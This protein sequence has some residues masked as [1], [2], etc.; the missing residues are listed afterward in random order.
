[1]Y[2][3][4]KL[5]KGL[6]LQKKSK[7]QESVLKINIE[8]TNC[9]PSV[10]EKNFTDKKDGTT[11]KNGTESVLKINIEETN[12]QPSGNEKNFTDKKD[13]TTEKNGTEAISIVD[14]EI[15]KMIGTFKNT[16]ETTQMDPIGP[17]VEF[18]AKNNKESSEDINECFNEKSNE[19]F[20]EKSNECFNEKSNECFNEKSNE[21]FN[22]KSNECFNEESNECFNEE[23]GRDDQPPRRIRKRYLIADGHYTT[24]TEIEEFIASHKNFNV[25]NLVDTFENVNLEEYGVNPPSFNIDYIFPKYPKIDTYLNL[26]SIPKEECKLQATMSHR[27]MIPMD[28]ETLFNT[29]NSEVCQV[30]GKNPVSFRLKDRFLRIKKVNKIVY[31]F[32]KDFYISYDMKKLQKW[33]ICATDLT[34]NNLGELIILEKGKTIN[35]YKD[36][37]LVQRV[38]LNILADG[39]VS[40]KD[41]TVVLSTYNKILFLLN[42]DSLDIEIICGPPNEKLVSLEIVDDIIVHRTNL[43]LYFID[44]GRR[45]RYLARFKTW[46]F[47]FALADVA[48]SLEGTNTLR[49]FDIKNPRNNISID[50]KVSIKGIAAYKDIIYL[51]IGDSIRIYRAGVMLEEIDVSQVKRDHD[52]TNVIFTE[53]EFERWKAVYNKIEKEKAEFIPNELNEDLKKDV[54]KI[55]GRGKLQKSTFTSQRSATSS[56][57]KKK[58][59]F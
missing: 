12:C 50:Y 30:F 55:L 51:S 28:E 57:R 37:N 8:E 31:M 2:Q 3:K 32:Y 24:G 7:K 29:Y 56:Q 27:I 21:C 9:Q 23:V 25:T 58:G 34:E 13:G 38:E 14:N 39:I 35:V 5:K 10:N 33:N 6:D 42:I 15:E 1:M 4:K 19:C 46:K 49:Y 52:F 41:R 47:P 59:G 45:I 36:Y 16:M 43:R 26:E 17:D 53:N 40:Y 54:D 18:V 48:I 44:L 11:E 20:N 22:E